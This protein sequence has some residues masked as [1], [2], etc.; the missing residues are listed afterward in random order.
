MVGSHAAKKNST[1]SPSAI[2]SAGSDAETM[3][4]T[5]TLFAHLDY[6]SKWDL[7]LA[8]QS[9]RRREIV[10]LMGF[11]VSFLD[12]KGVRDYTTP[13]RYYNTGNSCPMTLSGTMIQCRVVEWRHLSLGLVQKKRYTI[14]YS[15]SYRDEWY[16][17][18]NTSTVSWM[19]TNSIQYCGVSIEDPAKNSRED[20]CSLL[21][22]FRL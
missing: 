11:G 10:E 14:L 4:G 5:S 19:C 17:T 9:P 7:V 8:S 21:W 15:T 2:R 3:P 13:L 1:G 20:H 22:L 6:V 18:C 12:L 16:S